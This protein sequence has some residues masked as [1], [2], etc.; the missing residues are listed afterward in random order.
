[1]AVSKYGFT[2]FGIDEFEDWISKQT[3]ARTLTHIQL[4]HTW[5]PNY[6]AFTGQNHFE[7]QRG[8][9]DYHVGQHGWANIGQH[10]SIFPDGSVLTGRPLNDTPACIAGANFGGVCIENV[11]DFDAGRD[12]MTSD[13]RSAIVRV[14]A[15]LLRRFSM[16][17]RSGAGVVYH[18][19][20]DK[21]GN[22]KNGID[23][24]K[25]C[26]GTAFFGGNSTT[27]F[28]QHFLPPVLDQLA[29][30]TQVAAG[31]PTGLIRFARVTTQSLNFRQG[32]GAS[33][34]LVP[35]RVPAQLGSILRIWEERDGWV[36][37]S[38]TQQEW[39][40]ARFTVP[41]QRAVVNAVDC[42]VRDR[43]ADVGTVMQIVQR[44]AVVF[45]DAL[46]RGWARIG[47]YAWVPVSLI[48]VG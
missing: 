43:P 11:G 18:H 27:A 4:H 19:W 26:P 40:N 44:G 39:V 34:P 33:M 25:S 29:S 6:A 46:E 12:A 9:R 41:V 7:V 45:F 3:V 37:T 2:R 30:D 23:A 31:V 5:R 8:M 36:R 15:G 32:P 17:P 13:Q 24:V 20:F 42:N 14:T 22:R 16:I 47:P 38:N 35:K 1:M 48:D 21:D 10:F 28:E